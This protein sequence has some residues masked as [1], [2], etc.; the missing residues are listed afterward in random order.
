APALEDLALEEHARVCAR[1]QRRGG[2]HRGAVRDAGQSLCRPLDVVDRDGKLSRDQAALLVL[3]ASCISRPTG[4]AV[5][6]SSR[7]PSRSLPS[8]GSSAWAL[9]TLS[10][11]TSPGR[12]EPS[13]SS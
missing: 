7:S 9:V 10:S 12:S 1:V 11:T 2:E 6:C 3:P 5:R 4:T 8:R 13:A